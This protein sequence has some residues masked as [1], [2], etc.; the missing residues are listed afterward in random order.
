MKAIWLIQLGTPLE[1]SPR[2]VRKYLKE[3]LM[4]PRVLELNFFLRYFLVHFMIVPFRS[5]KSAEAYKKIWTK[6]GS[7]LLVHSRKLQEDLQQELGSDVLVRLSMTYGNPSIAQ[8]WK[9]LNKIELKHLVVVPLFPQY[10]SSTTGS[11]MERIMMEMRSSK[12]FPKLS[13]I[14][15]FFNNANFIQAF[16]EQGLQSNVKDYDHVLF[17]FHG[18]PVKSL[19]STSPKC[20]TPNCCKDK[21]SNLTICYR[22]QCLETARLIQESLSLDPEKTSLSFQSRLGKQAWIQPYTDLHVKELASK[23]VQ[24]L[25]VF[26]PSFVSDCLETL[27]EIGIRLKRSFLDAGGKELHLV[28]SLNDS[29]HWVKSLKSLF[30]E[31]Q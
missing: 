10:S 17:S 16:V 21:D 3:F 11:V 26:C 12:F 25:A 13:F 2:A 19:L 22:A 1:P 8:T 31:A 7:P 28:P 24:R 14:S 18:L 15:S 20:F 4:D 27:E 30:L 29:P 23:G 6:E 9:E 5:A